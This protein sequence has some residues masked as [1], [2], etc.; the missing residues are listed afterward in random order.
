M[1]KDIIIRGLT[2]FNPFLTRVPSL[3]LNSQ[4]FVSLKKKKLSK[5]PQ[6]SSKHKPSYQE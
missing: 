5:I 6:A 2:C 3:Q 4:N 1:I